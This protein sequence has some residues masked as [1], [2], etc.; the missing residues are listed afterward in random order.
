MKIII[1]CLSPDPFYLNSGD[2]I[3]LLELLHKLQEEKVIWKFSEIT[4]NLFPLSSN[5]ASLDF[6]KTFYHESDLNKI[7]SEIKL[8][9][10][11]FLKNPSE[12][13]SYFANQIKYLNNQ[14]EFS[15]FR[16]L[17]REV[18]KVSTLLINNNQIIGTLNNS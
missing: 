6:L 4:N 5:L 3:I 8:F 1:Y 17:T 9:E 10:E 12:E 7:D 14:G 13:N 11:S 15:L 16:I 18:D 2:E